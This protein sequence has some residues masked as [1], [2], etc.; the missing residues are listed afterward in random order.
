M[1]LET[2][3]ILSNP[4]MKDLIKIGRTTSD[5]PAIRISQLYTTGVPFPF[6]IEF[7][8]KVPNSEEV[9][10]ALHIAFAPHRPNPRREFFEMDPAQAIAILKL[11]HVEDV[12]AE[13]KGVSTTVEQVEI[14]AGD[15]YEKRR[16]N[17]NFI[18]M[19]IPVGAILKFTESEVSATVVAAK[20]VRLGDEEMS[21]TAA[22]RELLGI[23]YS[24]QPSPYWTYLGKSLKELYDETY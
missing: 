5:D 23:E 4:G 15:E 24:V 10:K 12:T 21:L 6:K 9:E 14:S 13:M 20:K 2:V 3:Y 7:A 16:P 17:L 8:C 11:L 19:G 22:T 18:E 1:T